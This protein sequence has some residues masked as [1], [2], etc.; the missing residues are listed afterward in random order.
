VILVR[1]WLPTRTIT[2][3]GDGNYSSI[4]LGNTCV[5][6]QVRLLVP[7]RLDAHLFAPPDARRPGQRGAPRVKGPALPKLASLL[8]DPATTWTRGVVPWYAQGC[9]ELEWC[10][11]QALWYHGG[12]A[13]LPIRWVLTRDPAGAHPPHAYLQTELSAATIPAGQADAVVTAPTILGANAATGRELLVRYQGR[14]RL[15]VTLEE[16]RAH[17]GVE[18]QRQW[19]KLA[20]ARSTPGLLGLFSVAVLCGQ[21]LHPDGRIPVAQAAW[22]HKNQATFSDVLA[23]VRG[24]LWNQELL[25]NRARGGEQ[26]TIR[27]ADLARVMQAAAA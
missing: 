5:R 4:D 27:S 26:I 15:E 14:W 1:R 16:S 19:S 6:Q 11:G 24:H 18:T 22:Y 3:L 12:K 9:Y 7:L 17:L 10:S 20:I 2:L 8:A 21:A 23:T 13:P 25:D